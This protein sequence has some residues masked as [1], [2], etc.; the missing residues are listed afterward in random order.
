MET[1]LTVM[2]NEIA[3]PG[4]IFTNSKNGAAGNA[5]ISWRAERDFTDA[6]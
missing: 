3:V 5:K 1:R 4:L 2:K 6:I